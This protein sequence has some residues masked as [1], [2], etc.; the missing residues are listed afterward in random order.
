MDFEGKVPRLPRGHDYYAAL[1]AICTSDGLTEDEQVELSAHLQNCKDCAQLLLSYRGVARSTAALLARS[2]NPQSA[3]SQK[4]WSIENAKKQLLNRIEADRTT[5]RPRVLR[6]RSLAIGDVL[7]AFVPLRVACAVLL[8]AVLAAGA[9][10]LGRIHGQHLAHQIPASNLPETTGGNQLEALAQQ[11]AL[12]EKL[13]AQSVQLQRLEREMELQVATI[14]ASK[15]SEDR[16][17]HKT[18]EQSAAIAALGS[19]KNALA[20][21]K[22]AV[23]HKLQE[24]KDALAAV[25]QRLD[26]LQAEHNRQLLHTASL[27]ARVDDLSY[28]LKQSEETVQRAEQF[29]ASDRD[30]RDLMGARDLYI[31]DVFD[32]DRD[33]KTQKAFGRVFYTGGKSLIFYAFDLDRQPGVREASAFQAWG[34]RGPGDKHPLSMGVLY[35]DNA[36]NRRWVLRFDDPKVLNEIDAV[37]V[38]IEPKGGGRKPTG[39]QLLF[40]SLRTPPN[41]P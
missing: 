25:Q 41:H 19:D 29:L 26:A 40:A 13:K 34:R 39:K 36:A 24:T 18:N 20:A 12:E 5:R 2:A 6:Q 16:L 23:L 15:S 7:R 9:Y 27:Q 37:F 31:A 3:T 4:N 28:T 8:I 22:D 32:I 11:R 21:E 17:E 14:A 10:H 33:G 35:E 38:T 1:C 30:I